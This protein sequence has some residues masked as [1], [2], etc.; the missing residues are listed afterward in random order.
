MLLGFELAAFGLDEQFLLLEALALEL[1]FFEFGGQL[2]SGLMGY[3][4]GLVCVGGLGLALGDG[5]QQFLELLDL[6]LIAFGL[7]PHLPVMHLPH[8]LS[9]LSHHSLPLPPLHLHT[10]LISFY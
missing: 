10:L 5:F 9:L 6:N 2:E 4:V 7:L 3:G 8:P 1:E